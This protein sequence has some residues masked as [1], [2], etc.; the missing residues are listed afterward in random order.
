MKN[1]LITSIFLLT[2]AQAFAL[3]SCPDSSG[4]QFSL[5]YNLFDNMVTGPKALK[6]QSSCASLNI[7]AGERY[8]LLAST[9]KFQIF[10]ERSF[11]S[12][13]STALVEVLVPSDGDYVTN[14]TCASPSIESVEIQSAALDLNVRKNSR[15][16]I[17]IESRG[18]SCEGRSALKSPRLRRSLRGRR[19]TG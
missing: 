4:S 6:A 16:Q 19:P 14:D 10:E 17:V 13:H 12:P 11:F 7:R 8:E 5:V 3:P 2:S 15:G 9:E 18:E 1:I